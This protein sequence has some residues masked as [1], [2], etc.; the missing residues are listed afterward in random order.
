[1]ESG[2]AGVQELQN[3]GKIRFAR[4]NS[5]IMLDSRSFYYS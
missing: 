2:V 3:T 5:Q 4:K 1:M